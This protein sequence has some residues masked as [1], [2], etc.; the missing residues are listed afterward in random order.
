MNNSSGSSY[1]SRYSNNGNAL[2]VSS[3][4]GSHNGG[5]VSPPQS[6]GPIPGGHV[7]LAVSPVSSSRLVQVS[8]FSESDEATESEGNM[9]S[10]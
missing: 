8:L 4:S 7:Q 10:R 5:R 1:N 3:R 9:G 6:G 2:S